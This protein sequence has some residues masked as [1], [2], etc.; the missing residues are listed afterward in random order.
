[1]RLDRGAIARRRQGLPGQALPWRTHLIL[2]CTGMIHLLTDAV[3]RL[4]R[5][6]A[7]YAEARHVSDEREQLAFV[8]SQRG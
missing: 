7:S 2:C 1:M 3:A 6:G 4:G 8:A 5:A